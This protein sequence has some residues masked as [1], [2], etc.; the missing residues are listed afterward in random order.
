MTHHAAVLDTWGRLP[1]EVGDVTAHVET[2]PQDRQ[3]LGL[4]EEVWNEFGEQAG[5]RMTSL[6]V[7]MYDHLTAYEG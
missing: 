4:A 3:V 1:P 5:Q 2:E 6:F 7:L